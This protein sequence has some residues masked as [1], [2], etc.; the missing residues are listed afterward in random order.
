[1]DSALTPGERLR[2]LRQQLGLTGQAVANALGMTKTAVSYWERGK[3]TIPHSVCLALESLY[4]VSANWLIQGIE[5]IWRPKAS[6]SS[7]TH[8]D[9]TFA[10]VIAGNTPFDDQGFPLPSPQKGEVI[11]L[12]SGFTH[13]LDAKGDAPQGQDFFW[14]RISDPAMRDTLG[15]QAFVLVDTRDESRRFISNHALYL[16]R[17]QNAPHACVRRLAIESQS[18]NVIAG[19]DERD[20]VP[21]RLVHDQANHRS[22]VLGRVLWI[23]RAATS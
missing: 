7:A 17:S 21:M 6:S 9:M 2:T 20:Q 10:P 11:G 19:T 13:P 5:P 3:V 1:M 14:I 22:V 18:G 16:V 12:P 23:L 15:N 4:G 8:S